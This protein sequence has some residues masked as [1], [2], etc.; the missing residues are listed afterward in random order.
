MVLGVLVGTCALGYGVSQTHTRGSARGGR[1]G[2]GA[3]G[4]PAPGRGTGGHRAV[5]AAAGTG[6]A[7]AAPAA[8]REGRP[9][10]AGARAAVAAAPDRLVLRRRRRP[11]R[12]LHRG[13]AE[14]LPGQA[15]ARSDGV[16]RPA[17]PAAP[18]RDDPRAH[19]RRAR[20]PVPR[21]RA[22]PGAA[23]RPLPHRPRALRGQDEQHRAVG[24]RRPGPAHDGGAVRGVVQPDPRRLVPRRLEVARPRLEAVRLG[25]ALRDVLLRRP[26]GALLLGLRR[27]RVRRR[28]ARL[29]QRARPRGHPAGSSTRSTSATR[30]SSTGADPPTRW[31]S[32][33]RVPSSA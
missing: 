1:A 24:G 29:R 28:L 10:P 20:Q 32:A 5:R 19:Q 15:R 3:R 33:Q 9:R 25:D 31:S 23:R 11:V 14:G 8:P 6:R 21:R 16:R 18:A 13:R 4:G 2:V 17:D 30:S 27:P 26:G 12:A 7:Q 22:H